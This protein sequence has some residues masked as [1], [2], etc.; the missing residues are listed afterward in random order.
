MKDEI[1]FKDFIFN[2]NLCN[3]RVNDQEIN[4]TPTEYRV[5]HLLIKNRGILL[6]SA[7]IRF[8]TLG[9]NHYGGDH[10]V[11]V[12]IGNLRKKIGRHHFENRPGFGYLFVD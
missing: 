2:P 8:S 12:H 5:L 11:S 6:S 4:L 1:I 7:N 10:A 9:P 3:I